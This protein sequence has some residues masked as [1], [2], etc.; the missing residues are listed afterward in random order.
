MGYLLHVYSYRLAF[1][2]MC[3]YVCVIFKYMD[4]L[5][6]CLSTSW[7]Y[8]TTKI[9]RKGQRGYEQRSSECCCESAWCS[10]IWL[11]QKLLVV[12]ELVK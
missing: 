6:C 12:F 5:Y 1:L 8:Q 2:R 7:S 11:E 9:L 10:V 4:R 3:V